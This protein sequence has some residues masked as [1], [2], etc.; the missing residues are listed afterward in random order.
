MSHDGHTLSSDSDEDPLQ[1]FAGRTEADEVAPLTMIQKSME[2]V[3]DLPNTVNSKPIPPSGQIHHTP[4]FIGFSPSASAEATDDIGQKVAQLR[5]RILE[6][7]EVDLYLLN[8]RRD[9][10]HE[11]RWQ[12][13]PL[14][15]A[16][17][18]QCT[19]YD[20]S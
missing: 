10:P 18:F 11:L 20:L 2:G 14:L 3:V 12:V 5:R 15:E 1:A 16:R 7:S 4:N 17:I 19:K 9:N 8:E 13:L 6:K